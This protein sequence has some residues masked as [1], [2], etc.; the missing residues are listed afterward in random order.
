MVQT[1]TKLLQLWRGN[2]DVK[3]MLYDTNPMNPDIT[4]I[5]QVCDYLVSYATKG[6]ETLAIEKKT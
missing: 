1:A 6:A 4:T 5:L 2:C 3:I